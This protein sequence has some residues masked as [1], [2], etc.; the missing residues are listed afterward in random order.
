MASTAAAIVF[1]ICAIAELI[2]DKLPMT[3]KR[4]APVGLLARVATG[5]L[6]GAALCVAGGQSLA[7]G[8]VLGGIGAVIGAFG[9]YQI[10][11]TLLSKLGIK[12]VFIA[13]CEDVIAIALACLLVKV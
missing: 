7:I 8:L 3:P 4:T 13:I 6:C 5:A 12:D 1:S 2:V 9:G 11:S 10:R